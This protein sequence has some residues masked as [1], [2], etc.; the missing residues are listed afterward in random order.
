[1]M[2]VATASGITQLIVYRH[3]ESKEELYRAVLYRVCD[4]LSAEWTGGTES[5]GFGVGART[6]LNSARQD[7]AGFRLLWRHAARE[8]LFCSYTSELREQ[9]TGAVADSLRERVPPDNL[10][11][12]AH[13]T[14][15]YLVEAVLNWLE[16]GDPKRDAMFVKATNAAMRA[17]VRAWSRETAQ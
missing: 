15:G 6:V 9:A 11:W 10:E 14:V 4:R 16:F 1:M 12:A 5:R 7:P 8:P 17:G 13:A 3:F 2:D